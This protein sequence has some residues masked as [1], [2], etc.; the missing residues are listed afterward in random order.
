[1]KHI[2]NYSFALLFPLLLFSC[3]EE[4]DMDSQNRLLAVKL[5]S[6]TGDLNFSPMMH[7]DSNDVT[8]FNVPV[9]SYKGKPYSGKIAS[10][11]EDQK[12]MLE[13]TL[14]NGI[15]DGEWIFYYPSGSVHIEGAY[16]NGLESGFWTSYFSRDKPKIVKY[17]DD[18]GYMLMRKEYFS[19]GRIKNYQNVK[20]PE[21]GDRQRRI[22][23]KGTGEL[24]YIDAE[25]EV[26]QLPPS[27]INDLLKNDKLMKSAATGMN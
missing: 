12:I 18:K 19:N 9:Y 23:F 21:F 20:C 14:T 24:E 13:G 10:Y 26:G 25:R 6:S 7:E 8:E 11:T 1:M 17:Y 16:K 27:M 2:L 3:S 5:K 22:E 4:K 15:A